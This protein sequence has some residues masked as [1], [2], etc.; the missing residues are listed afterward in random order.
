MLATKSIMINLEFIYFNVNLI[1]FDSILV[2]LI[3]L[4]SS[5]VPTIL[6]KQIKPITI[7][8]AKE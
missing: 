6:I 7:I 3:S 2:L 8:K 5:I 4:L 1:S